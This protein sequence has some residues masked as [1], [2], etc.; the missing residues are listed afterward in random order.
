MNCI[1]C[2][3]TTGNPKFCSRSCSAT[4]N[5]YVIGARHGKPENYI[6]KCGARKDNKAKQCRLCNRKKSADKACKRPIKYF[7]NNRSHPVYRHSVLRK[8]AKRLMDLRG[9]EKKCRCGYKLHVE[10]CHV[11]PIT[12]FDLDT[13]M[14]EVNSKDNLIYLCRNCHWELDHDY[15]KL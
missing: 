11:K 12:S 13:L 15:L 2:G 14:G 7:A 5:N 6:C 9:I 3:K 8:W 1:N 4:F 10:C